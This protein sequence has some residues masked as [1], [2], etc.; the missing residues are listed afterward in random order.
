MAWGPHT[1]D[2]DRYVL[3]SADCHGGGALTD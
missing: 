2:D 1:V 3:I